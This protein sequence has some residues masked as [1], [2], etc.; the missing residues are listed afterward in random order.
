MS[1]NF[2]N[3]K[4]PFK[5]DNK[6]KYLGMNNRSDD[7]I[8]SDLMHLLLT[9]RG[10]RLYLPEFGTN[11][12]RYLFEPNLDGVRNDIKNEI[13]DAVD[14]FIPNL[15]ISELTV[16]KPEDGNGEHTAIVRIDYIVTQGAFQKSDTITLTI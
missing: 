3:I 10:E 8:R 9:N 16:T 12:R 15:I 1:E 14:K 13:Q 4:F 2:I 6:G 11:L 7:A 5:D